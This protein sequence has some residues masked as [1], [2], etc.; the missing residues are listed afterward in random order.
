M[1]LT[2]DSIGA[3]SHLRDPLKEKNPRRSKIQRRKGNRCLAGPFTRLKSDNKQQG[4]RSSCGCGHKLW[5]SG[6]V[7]LLC[8]VMKLKTAVKSQNIVFNS[9][10]ENFYTN[11]GIQKVHVGVTSKLPRTPPPH[12]HPYVPPNSSTLNFSVLLLRK[13]H[14]AAALI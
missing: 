12:P 11:F 1:F 5:G 7:A 6:G 4:G 9:F 2:P 10:S 8:D 3:A 13:A 14:R